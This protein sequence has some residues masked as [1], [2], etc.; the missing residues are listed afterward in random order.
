MTTAPAAAAG[1]SRP[2]KPPR[3]TSSAGPLAFLIGAAVLL[4]A[5]VVH[6]VL[7]GY[8]ADAVAEPPP[9]WTAIAN[10]TELA[11]GAACFIAAGGVWRWSTA[12]RGVSA[13][14]AA[15]AALVLLIVI[16]ALFWA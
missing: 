14:L 12:R 10:W 8:L 3:G 15:L 13:V 5:A 7:M 16:T 9:T 6:L 1:G 11:L 4:G 2:E